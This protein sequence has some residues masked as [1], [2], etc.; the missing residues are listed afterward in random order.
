M[1]QVK[2][3]TYAKDVKLG[4]K[5]EK[6][7]R[8]NFRKRYNINLIKCPGGYYSDFIDFDKKIVI[9]LKRRDTKLLSFK[10]TLLCHSKLINFL[11]FNR[12]NGGRYVFIMVFHFNDGIYYFEHRDG[13]DYIVKPYVRNPRIGYV[14]KIKPYLFIPVRLLEPMDNIKKY[15]LSPKI[16]VRYNI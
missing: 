5:A 14:D 11:R 13:Y 15:T 6:R 10:Y 4:K 9:E 1:S 3:S 8:K 16:L 2:Q 7:F 12:R